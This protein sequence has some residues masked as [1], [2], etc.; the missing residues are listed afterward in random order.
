[1]DCAELTLNQ[2]VAN[3]SVPNARDANSEIR[4]GESQVN[5]L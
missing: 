3:D 5:S 2:F 1:L 4:V